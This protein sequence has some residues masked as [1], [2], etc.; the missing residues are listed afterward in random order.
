MPYASVDRSNIFYE[1]RPHPPIR[2]RFDLVM[3]HGSGAWHFV[4]EEQLANLA[5]TANLYAL[6]LPGHGNSGRYGEESVSAYA[7]C[8]QGFVQSLSLEKVVLCGNSLGGAVVIELCIRYPLLAKGVILIGTGARLRVMPEILSLLE[9]DPEAFEEMLSRYAFSPKT[10]ED[11]VESYF[12]KAR[13]VPVDVT[14]GDFKACDTFDRM[15]E[16]SQIKAPSLVV[17]GEDD[18]L[19]P[20]KYARY[21]KEN[22][23]DA[24]LIVVPEC[25]HLVMM[26]KPALLNKYI[27][28]FLSRLSCREK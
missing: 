18:K 10:P 24:S 7:E 3:I 9:D 21:L 6:D 8:V 13:N 26:E 2:D 4:W 19:T 25:G 14:I 12:E 28:E 15:K 22:I 17:V 20:V 27:K 16:V 5:D 23:P 11:I 1:A